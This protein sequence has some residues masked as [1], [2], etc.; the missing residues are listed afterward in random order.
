M[1]VLP[2]FNLLN[3]KKV[4]S[5]WYLL[6]YCCLVAKSC[7]TLLRPHGLLPAWLTV[8]GVSQARILEWVASVSGDLLDSG[9]KP[10]SLA[11]PALAGGFFIPEPPPQLQDRGKVIRFN[12]G[13]G[14][15][16]LCIF[17]KFKFLFIYSF[18]YLA[19]SGSLLCH[20]GSFL[21]FGLSS[22]SRPPAIAS[23]VPLVAL[24][25]CGI[26]V[27]HCGLNLNLLHCRADS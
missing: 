7:L 9:I 23:T 19:A 21:A 12:K 2:F 10:M 8:H 4:L 27:P 3:I 14:G 6:F 22:C 24:P 18:I 11:S 17:R 20:V 15:W 13:F 5:I 16:D 1:R 26:V 25:A